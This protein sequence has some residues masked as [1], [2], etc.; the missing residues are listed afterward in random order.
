[1]RATGLST[2]TVGGG[3]S[4]YTEIRIDP[5]DTPDARELLD[6]LAGTDD[7]LEPL[8]RRLIDRTAGNPFFL[9]ESVRALAESGGLRGTPGR[10]TVAE[11]V[12]ELNVPATVESLLASRIDRLHA[13]DKR[14]LLRASVIG[15]RVPL[16]V[17]QA[18]T[19]LAPED[20]RQALERLQASGFLYE[21]TLFPEVEHTFRHALVH[22]VAYR[23]I[24]L[25]GR[26]ALHR[27]GL[28]AGENLYADRIFEKADWLAYH[29]LRGQV[30][31]RAV[32]YFRSSAARAVR[33]AASRIAVQHLENA[34]VAAAHLSDAERSTVA[35][36]LRIELRHALTP[37]GQVQRTLE[38]LEAAEALAVKMGD[39][40]RLGR[41][42]SFTANCLLI[43]A[44]HREALA[45]GARALAIAQELNDVSLRV[46][47]RIYMARAHVARGQCVAPVEL[48]Q[49]TIGI[50]DETAPD[51]FLGLPVLPAAYARSVLAVTLATTGNFGEAAAHASEAARRAAVSRQPDSIVWANWSVGLVAMLRG[52]SG[53]AVRIF[54]DLH[55][56][57]RAHDLDAYT[58]RAMAALGCARARAG[59]L[60]EGL[61]LLERAVGMDASAEP[62][63]TRSFALN[64]LAEAL[65]L[66][67]EDERALA[68][69]NDALQFARDHEERGAEAHACFVMGLLHAARGGE[70]EAAAGYLHDAGSIASECGLRPLLAHCRLGLSGLHRQR[71]EPDR[72]RACL[73]EGR[74]LLDALGMKPW[75]QIE[76]GIGSAAGSAVPTGCGFP[77]LAPRR[78]FT[79]D[80]DARDVHADAA[81]RCLDFDDDLFGQAPVAVQANFQAHCRCVQRLLA[82]VS[83]HVPQREAILR[84]SLLRP[85]PDCLLHRFAGCAGCAA[86]EIHRRVQTID[87]DTH[88]LVAERGLQIGERDVPLLAPRLV[89]RSLE[90]EYDD[91]M[92]S[93]FQPVFVDESAAHF[94]A[95]LKMIFVSAIHRSRYGLWNVITSIRLLKPAGPSA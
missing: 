15:Y 3:K 16:D 69:C 55:G 60:K 42:V 62:K 40:Q 45:T 65:L 90:G 4:Y 44:R 51:D 8:K 57:C 46:A 80:L 31:D 48:L 54:E 23:S 85:F 32:S 87:G 72:A 38:N 81:G 14:V 2:G 24:S 12:S 30:W 21:T 43:Q 35:V 63:T 64:A 68:A 9:E 53:E 19:Q 27:Q 1:L 20:L 56:L 49:E 73:D 77:C 13:G 94:A 7:A 76:P 82:I 75:F 25:D 59:L 93:R 78:R 86:R 74:A 89:D 36:D 71:H 39:R 34:L 10:Y 66:S 79:G 22:D 11:A 28:A 18:L 84:T 47:T 26:R 83:S 29:A 5:L 70:L 37:L 6:V 61:A 58:S 33:R 88:H 67:G 92:G 95:P 91:L 50:L 52:A 17:L 41:I